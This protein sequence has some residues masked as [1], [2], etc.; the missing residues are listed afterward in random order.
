MPKQKA[1]P[2]EEGHVQTKRGK[3]I[4]V[5]PPSAYHSWS[6]GAAHS[7]LFD[8]ETIR[9]DETSKFPDTMI[10]SGIV[11][12]IECEKINLPTTLWRRLHTYFVEDHCSFIITRTGNSS[13]DIES[14]AKSEVV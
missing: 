8:P 4:P 1:K 3:S 2:V 14:V 5:P 7:V 13:W 6:E 10:C 11:D 9:I 12:G